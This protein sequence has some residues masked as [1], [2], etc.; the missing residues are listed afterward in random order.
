MDVPAGTTTGV[1]VVVP[2]LAPSTGNGDSDRRGDV[3]E[4]GFKR[5]TRDIFLLKDSLKLHCPM[6]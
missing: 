2:S 1:L 5:W 4:R 6:L 3:G